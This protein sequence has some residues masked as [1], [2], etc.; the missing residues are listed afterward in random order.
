MN[1]CLDVFGAKR[2]YCGLT[3]RFI[4]LFYLT[5]VCGGLVHTPRVR[6]KLNKDKCQMIKKE[7]E[8]VGEERG[9]EQVQTPNK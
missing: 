5:K 2:A 7:Q 3:V 1:S 8:L 9:A 6:P 4:E